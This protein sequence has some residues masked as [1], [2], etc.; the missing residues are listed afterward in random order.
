MSSNRKVYDITNEKILYEDLCP[1]SI[2]YG[3]GERKYFDLWM[4]SRRTC[5]LSYSNFPEEFAP[6]AE[7][8]LNTNKYDITEL[9]LNPGQWESF[10][11]RTLAQSPFDRYWIFY[12]KP[13]SQQSNPNEP[14]YDPLPW[15]PM[16]VLP[17]A[18]F[19]LYLGNLADTYSTYANRDTN[20]KRSSSSNRKANTTNIRNTT[21][22]ATL[23]FNEWVNEN[24]RPDLGAELIPNPQIYTTYSKVPGTSF[25]QHHY[26]E[27]I[28]TF[29]YK[30]PH[31]WERLCD[32]KEY[33]FSAKSKTVYPALAE[34][35]HPDLALDLS[36]ADELAKY[37]NRDRSNTYLIRDAET[38]K[39]LGLAP[40]TYWGELTHLYDLEDNLLPHEESRYKGYNSDSFEE[41]FKMAFRDL[42][43]T[44]IISRVGV[45]TGDVKDWL[46]HREW[47]ISHR[48]TSQLL[49]STMTAFALNSHYTLPPT[50]APT[51]AGS[52][53]TLES[54]N[55]SF[56]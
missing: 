35:F 9:P 56:D 11:R 55:P 30:E 21:F 36:L 10:D 13:R 18:D 48:S 44:G 29:C 15:Y 22:F 39:L 12:N 37:R 34:I 32:S 3:K 28:D 43:L 41:T 27:K 38:G 33:L 53:P 54:M 31:Y 19:S 6:Q 23:K 16:G 4:K 24:I 45:T 47:D 49:S 2:V 40:I 5:F 25:D 26:W 50:Q 51:K 14:T 7:D 46:T 17:K 42:H 8:W 20:T 1:G 52:S